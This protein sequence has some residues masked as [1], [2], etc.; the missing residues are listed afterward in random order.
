MT[1]AYTSGRTRVR[2]APLVPVRQDDAGTTARPTIPGPRERIVVRPTRSLRVTH[3]NLKARDPAF[4]AEMERG[5]RELSPEDGETMQRLLDGVAATP[6]ETL[7]KLIGYTRRS[8]P[9]A[10]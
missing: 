4:V 3:G 9:S 2:I 7:T 5:R 1:A 10:R 6:T 8:E